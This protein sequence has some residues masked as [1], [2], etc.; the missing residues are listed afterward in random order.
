[1]DRTGTPHA[2]A[3]G[4][5]PGFTLVELL[6]V[7]TII[8]ILMSMLLPAV[9]QVRE[10]GRQAACRSNIR[11]LGIALDAYHAKHGILP[12]GS[13]C[14]WQ[15]KPQPPRPQSEGKGTVLHYLLP[16]VDMQNIYDLLKFNQTIVESPAPNVPGLTNTSIWQFR[17][18]VFV[19][20]SDSA[21]G[22][23]TA[24]NRRAL[25][26]YV[27]SAG[28][29]GLSATGNPDTPC[30]CTNPYTAF[31]RSRRYAGGPGP[32]YRHHSSTTWRSVGYS[33]IRDGLATTIM[34]GEIR[35]G[36]SGHVRSGW[37]SSDN[38][39]G[40]VSTTIPINYDTCNETEMCKI[41]GCQARANGNTALGFKS[42][43]PGGAIFLMG[44][45]SVH[46]F[47]ESIDHQM[48][49]YL[50]AIDDGQ[51]ARIP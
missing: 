7:I 32:F 38:G 4:L 11:Q 5:R 45:Q 47:S 35:W 10:A 48:Y 23:D 3:P 1:V 26:N 6:V 31:N 24:N 2:V 36:C 46:F 21:R 49:Q 28:P 19:C 34:M 20:P 9:G 22:V 27:G 37:F 29:L 30:R 50:G 42:S 13:W 39:S 40:V 33:T 16:F 41:D 17:I 14:R 44:D 51:P 15:D 12:L 25:T 43:H 8:G 18:P